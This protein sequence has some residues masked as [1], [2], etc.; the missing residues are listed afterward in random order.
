MD[1]IID[2]VEDSEPEREV[3]RKEVQA[4]KRRKRIAEVARHNHAASQQRSRRKPSPDITEDAIIT[5]NTTETLELGES[6]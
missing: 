1:G 6:C 3:L 2:I 4:Q 5:I